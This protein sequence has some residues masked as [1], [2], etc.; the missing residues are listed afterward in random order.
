MQKSTFY[1]LLIVLL[2]MP[3]LVSAQEAFSY[4]AVVRDSLGDVLPNQVIGLR[5]SIIQNQDFSPA[6]YIEEHD[7]STNDY[8][9]VNLKVGEGI[10]SLGNFE[11]IDWGLK[12]FLKIEIDIEG[13]SNYTLTSVSE[14]LSAPKAIYAERAGK[15]DGTRFGLIVTDFGAVGDGETDDTD[16]FEAALDSA[17]I[18]G[19]KVFV[20]VGIY[21]ITRTLIIQD[22]V[23]L[24]GEGSGSDPLE[25]PYNGS[26]IWY[27]GNDFAIKINGHNTRIEDVVIRDKSDEQ[28][29]GGIIIEADGRLVESIHLSEVLISGFVNGTGFKLES[30]NAGGITY[31]TFDNVRIRHGNIG[32][33][34]VQD[35]T[36]FVNSNTWNNCQVSGGAFDYGVYIDGGNNNNFN[37]LI[38]EPY[39]SISGHFYVNKGQVYG[40]EIRIEG[41]QQDETVPLIYFDRNTKNSTLTGVYAGGLTIDK[42]N[43]FINMRSGRAIHYKNSSFNKFLN[44]TF[45]MP[46][47][48]AI[49]DW[50][51]DGSYENLTILEPELTEIHNVLKLEIPSGGKLRLEPSPLSRPKIKELSIYDQVNFGFHVKTDAPEMVYAFTNAENG[52]TRST[53]HSGGGDWEFV[54][55]NAAVDRNQQGRFALEIDNNTGSTQNVYITTPTLNFGNQLPTLDEPPLFSSGGQLYGLLIDAFAVAD[56]PNNGFLD[57]PLS[58]N[59]FEVNGINK[60]YR[61]N[62][63]TANRFPRG[64]VITLLFNNPGV[65]IYKSG[66]LI[67]N[68]NMTTGENSSLTLISNGNGTW[69]EVSRNQ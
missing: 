44:A 5:S 60:V 49:P 4:Q 31:S 52:W 16:A 59:Y 64:S 69:R 26:L 8:G 18:Y 42:G 12:S 61:V 68:A 66:Y 21:K 43:N 29:K 54:G 17:L 27:Y 67:L 11:N 6:I 19:C 62:H 58:A 2:S 25:T 1:S 65:N 3:I 41:A 15:I 51:L 48:L 55:M 10:V 14:I 57:L 36:S 30:K 35:N 32:I 34:L 46:D 33:H 28:A 22:G 50:D 24:I 9:V 39:T 40:S 23:S 47:D 63:V 20:P 13:G 37:G 56:I 38:V 53:F 45:F 7:I